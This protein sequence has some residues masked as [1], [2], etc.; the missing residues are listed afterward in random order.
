[1]CPK[2]FILKEL[3]SL[4]LESNV[5]SHHKYLSKWV[6]KYKKQKFYNK[7]IVKKKK[8]VFHNNLKKK[9]KT[10][11]IYN[12]ILKKKFKELT[13]YKNDYQ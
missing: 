11:T 3:Y 13:K 2:L 8:K 4:I 12:N 5:G 9:K 10:W 6:I 7:C 1:M